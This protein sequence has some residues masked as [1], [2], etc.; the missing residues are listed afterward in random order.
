M[1]H[2]ADKKYA[3]SPSYQEKYNIKEIYRIYKSES[4]TFLSRGVCSVSMK[5]KSKTLAKWFPPQTAQKGD[6]D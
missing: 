1:H 6:G 3:K 2:M 4:I 5:T